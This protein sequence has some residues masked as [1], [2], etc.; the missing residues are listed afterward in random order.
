MKKNDRLFAL[1]MVLFTVFLVVPFTHH[2]FFNTTG[3]YPIIGGFV[4]F[5]L[6]A[7]IGDVLSNRLV[8]RSY[9]VNGLFKKAIVWGFIGMVIAL[10]FPLFY[11]GVAYLQSNNLLPFDSSAFAL[12]LFVSV[13]MNLIFAPT[14]MLF[15][16]VTD[17]YIENI[18]TKHFKTFNDILKSIDYEG[19]I[20][21]VVFKTIPFFWIP[22]HTITFL[23][24]ETYR[25]FFAS[26]LGVALGLLLGI[27]KL[28]KKEES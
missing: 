8:K 17:A 19:F 5:F 13:F 24:P 18:T 23:L 2:W 9:R 3:D 4:K 20:T 21:F 6:F 28:R 1:T 27:G 7:S 26:L 16:R 12:A 15:H 22:A 25:V 14:M 10:V 11:H